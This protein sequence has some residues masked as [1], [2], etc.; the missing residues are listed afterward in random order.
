MGEDRLAGAGLAGDRV[1]ALA[2]AQLG[3][4]DQQQVLD[5]QLA[6]HAPCVATGAD[7]LPRDRV[8]RMATRVLV[9]GAGF[10]GLELATTPLRRARR[11]RSRSP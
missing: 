11:A 7:R 9:L 2:E 5:S 4:L 8:A 3:A 6:Q 10:G 1:E